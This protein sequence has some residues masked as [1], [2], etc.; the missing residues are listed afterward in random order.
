MRKKIV[1]GNW[2]MNKT[3]DEAVAL[4]SEVVNMIADEVTSDVEVVLCVPS[5]YLSTLQQ[6]ATGRVSI[7]A[8]NCHQKA[9]GAYTGEISASMLKSVGI[10][11]V[12]LGHSERRQYF[13][14]T[15]EILAEKVNISLENGLKPIFC[16]GESLEQRQNEDYIA[17]VQTQL[18]NALFHLSAEQFGQIVIAYEPIWAIGTGLT[19]S[20]QQAQDM[21]AALRSHIAG[22][23]GQEV[24]DNTTIQ[25][26][27]S[28]NAANAAEIFASPDVDGGLVGGASLKSRDFVE[29]VK[30]I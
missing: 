29:I 21:H 19:A 10:P 30:A 11:Y 7:G 2:K 12:I 25:Y 14:E 9:S 6:Y 16:C 5:L 3:A 23:Y 17:I 13:G 26:G 27:G 8:Q 28:V 4:T 15:D 1:A 24:A 22:K 18:T 20:A